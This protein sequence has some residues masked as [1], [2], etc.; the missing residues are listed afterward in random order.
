MRIL[1]TGARGFIGSHL[2]D[3]LEAA[4]HVVGKL[5][6][7]PDYQYADD[8]LN[9]AAWLDGVE[10]AW[11]VVVHLAA[12]VGRLFGEDDLPET[13][14]DNAA[15]TAVVAKACG[16][17]GVRLVYASTSEVY[18]DC[19]DGIAVEDDAG[20]WAELYGVAAGRHLPHNLYGLSKRWGE[21]ACRLYAPDR[22][23]IWRISMP[24]GPGLP[25]GRGRAA[26]VNMLWQALHRQPIPVHRGAERSWCWIGDT[27]RAMRL[28]IEATGGGVFNVGRDDAAV[29]MRRVAELACELAGAP[30]SLIEEVAPPARQTVVKRLSTAKLRS[31]GWQ[32]EVELEDGMRQMLP[33]VLAQPGPAEVA[34]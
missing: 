27:V 16:E 32:P 11:D 26:I 30:T 15:L 23:T 12:K 5:D 18:G 14:R 1:V 19:G 4:G 7:N 2:C 9:I 6:S 3:E 20:L 34:A 28:T 24:Y 10:A 25:A 21:D 13:I 29:T 31:L 33:W 22:L 8:A 17:R